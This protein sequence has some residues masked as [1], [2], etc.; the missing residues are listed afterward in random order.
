LSLIEAV[1]AM[2]VALTIY[3]TITVN[4][5][6]GAMRGIMFF[7]FGPIILTTASVIVSA[8]FGCFYCALGGA[9]TC[10]IVGTII[11]E[12]AIL[13]FGDVYVSKYSGGIFL[14][15]FIAPIA[16]AIVGSLIGILILSIFLGG[17]CGA[18]IGILIARFSGSTEDS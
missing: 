13:H 15:L 2:A 5:I 11:Y 3:I 4:F 6:Y 9:V 10:I 1:I 7:I 18:V 16:G 14:V 8:F 12:S 17:V